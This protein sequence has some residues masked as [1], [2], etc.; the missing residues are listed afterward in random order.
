MTST[1][2]KSLLICA[3]NLSD[4]HIRAISGV[5]IHGLFL[6]QPIPYDKFADITYEQEFNNCSNP[7]NKLIKMSMKEHVDS[8][9]EKGKL[10]LGTFKYYK[11]VDNPEIGDMSE[12]SLI[13]VGRSEKQTAF[14]E[15]GS[16]FNN[17]VFCCYDGD[18]N[19]EVVK[20]FG[21]DDYFEITDVNGFSESIKNSL[22]AEKSYKSRCIYKKDK[23]LVD[24]IPKDFDFSVVSAKLKEMV[25]ETK[26]FLK[27]NEYNHQKEFRFTWEV[28]SDIEQPIIIDCLEATKFCRRP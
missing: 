13:I 20:K 7:K 4:Q 18:A 28:E 11:Q 5:L 17:Y 21:Y 8:F 6:D 9:F 14:A 2:V 1:Y 16:G 24:D 19:P 10:Q 3:P 27:T 25:N 23:V 12:G 15:I 26:Y 22:K